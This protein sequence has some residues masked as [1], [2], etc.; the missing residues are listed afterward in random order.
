MGRDTVAETTP[1]VKQKQYAGV[2]EVIVDSDDDHRKADDEARSP[3]KLHRFEFLERTQKLRKSGEHLT[4]DFNVKE[5]LTSTSNK[6]AALETRRHSST[7]K[8]PNCES[9]TEEEI[10]GQGGRELQAEQDRRGG[11][12]LDLFK[13]E[14]QQRL[15]VGVDK[16]L[17]FHHAFGRKLVCNI[18]L[19]KT[20]RNGLLQDS[21]QHVTSALNSW[22]ISGR[23]HSNFFLKDEDVL[24]LRETCWLRACYCM[25]M[26]KE[27]A[28][29]GTRRRK[30][31]RRQM[32][33]P[34]GLLFGYNRA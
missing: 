28:E 29:V 12:D 16:L 3:K 32:L 13:D 15:S 18:R 6:E 24:A 33:F 27:I 10:E 20:M 11:T 2:K 4:G 34:G 9:F 7:P 30:E 31:V 8:M 14:V 22:F 5:G 21:E 26:W 1:N 19:P 17:E 23:H 25:R